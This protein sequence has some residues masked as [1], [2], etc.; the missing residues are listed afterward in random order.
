MSIEVNDNNEENKYKYSRTY[1]LIF[2][3]TNDLDVVP[4][5]IFEQFAQVG[6][7]RGLANKG[8]R[9]KVHFVLAGKIDNIIHVLLGKGGQVNNDTW[10]IHIFALS[11]GAV[12]FNSAGHFSGSFIAGQDGQNQRSISNQNLLSWLDT[13]GQG[14]V[15][16]SQLFGVF[17]IGFELVIAGQN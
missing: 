9:D 15:G 17:G 4:T 16:A 8:G 10:Q 7:I 1:L 11:N 6:H 5:I 12:I 2:N 14:G 3:L 13:L